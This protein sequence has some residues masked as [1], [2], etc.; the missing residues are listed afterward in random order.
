[1]TSPNVEIA[2]DFFHDGLDFLHRY[3]LTLEAFLT[4]R[5]RRLKLFVDLRMA[6]ECMLKSLV[7]YHLSVETSREM[8]IRK[9]EGYRH[10]IS[11]LAIDAEVHIEIKE[12]DAIHVFLKQLDSLPVALRYRLDGIDFYEWDEKL[13]H[14]TVGSNNWMD[15]LYE[16]VKLVAYSLDN[17]LKSH[18]CFL[19][20]D[21]LLKDTLRI[22]HNKYV[23]KSK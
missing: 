2:N 8:V 11:K 16:V 22:K 4:I 15:Q 6:M 3:Q 23:K 18:S 9:V 10:N 14:D 20:S 17:N 7:S 5:S 21:A 1:M 13:Y 19:S 12:K